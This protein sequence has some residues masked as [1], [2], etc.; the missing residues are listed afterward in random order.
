MHAKT[1]VMP[2]LLLRDVV[3]FPGETIPVIL[4]G[5][6][7]IIALD[8]ALATEGRLF[9]VAQR[10]ARIEEPKKKD[11][12]RVGT[13]GIVDQV[14]RLPD[15]TVKVLMEGKKRAT[16]VE[17]LQEEEFVLVKIQEMEEMAGSPTEV[18]M[19][20]REF[21]EIIEDFASLTPETPA[22]EIPSVAGLEDPSQLIDAI[23]AQI[24]LELSDK[25]EF[26]ETVVVTQR[27]AKLLVLLKEQMGALKVETEIQS[28]VLE[29]IQ[30][31]KKEYILNE[32][33]HAIRRELGE[34]DEFE[35][36]LHALENRFRQ[37]KMP[38]EARH[39]VARDLERLQSMPPMAEE[40]AV[41][42]NYVDCVLSLPWCEYSRDET[43][44][45]KAERI[46]EE[47][48]YG[49]REVKERVL[50]YLAARSL[51]PK[52]RAPILCFVGP[53]GVGKTSLGKSIATA[54]GR[55][56][57]RASLGGVRDE[58][59]IRGHRR[60]YIGSMPGRI[61]QSLRKAELGNPVFLLDEV[62]KLGTD[63]RGDPSSALL[64]VLDPHENY[65]F[66]DHYLEL[67]YDLSG[68][69][70]ITTA[71]ALDSIPRPLQDRMEIIRIAGYVEP[72]K[73]HITKRYL[74]PKQLEIHGHRQDDLV[75]TDK[76]LLAI[77]RRYTREPGVR[78]LER[79]IAKVC[80]KSAREVLA[81]AN[82]ARLR[83]TTR[84]VERYLGK[85]RYRFEV[86]EGESRLGA[87]YGMTRT[88]MG[89]ELLSVEATAMPGKG[90]LYITGQLGEVM[91]ES[92][93]AALSYVRSR[94]QTLSLDPN[95]YQKVDIH[96]HVPEGDIPKD[97]P[98]LGISLATS[99][100]SALTGRPVKSDMAMTG[101]I[102]LQGRVLPVKGIKEKI[103]AVHRGNIRNVFIP[104]ANMKDIPE[105]PSQVL[106]HVELTLVESLDEVLDRA[107]LPDHLAR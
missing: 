94:S 11:I 13:I 69:L 48:H 76:A 104:K 22:S 46:L 26:L 27:L 54:T 3:L 103:L 40:T 4:G 89:G 49:L 67:V 64:E 2:L 87:A 31:E 28:R 19:L 20:M 101:E 62:D 85:P 79:Q 36:E 14:S 12:Y 99:M 58:A 75:F 77:I 78:N 83:V 9:C 88:D 57:L 44:L 106:R 86:Q 56:F 47:S 18:E 81:E 84:T 7:S 65:A 82:K 66:N 102:T 35:D 43:D 100:A 91:Q 80:R 21:Q 42:R 51:A 37:K 34:N 93:Q 30:K 71:N 73:L 25:Q 8:R 29:Q 10:D 72:E 50:E 38:E 55:E 17:Y 24:D 70:F 98:S 6:K 92:A 16:L 33:M 41:L 95:L 45:D 53:P 52:L 5:E 59:D 23:V 1:T 90:N 107:L 68:I 74:I 60:T 61:I 39:R 15:G 32:Q 97:G 96:V 63:F 105:V